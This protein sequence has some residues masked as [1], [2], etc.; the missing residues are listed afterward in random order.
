MSTTKVEKNA[1]RDGNPAAVAATSAPS[2]PQSAAAP[3]PFTP[4]ADYA[5]LSDCHTGALVAPDGT[6]QSA[7]RA[8]DE[9]S[10][11]DLEGAVG[12]GRGS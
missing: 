4:I 2:M 6:E 7:L 1:Q 10:G 5:F 3:S 12:V 11:Y 9:H 8:G